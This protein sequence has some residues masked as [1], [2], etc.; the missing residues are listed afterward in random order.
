[1]IL[2]TNHD[3]DMLRDGPYPWSLKQRVASR[4][5]HLSNVDAVAGLE[6]LMHDELQAVVLYHLSQTNNRPALAAALAGEELDRLGSR[7][8]LTVS[9]QSEPTEWIEVI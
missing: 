9:G 2:E 3:L 1:L 6:E 7:S 5:G 4:H 8:R